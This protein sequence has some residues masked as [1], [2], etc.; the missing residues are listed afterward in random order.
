MTFPEKITDIVNPES[1]EI[2]ENYLQLLHK[3][4]PLVGKDLC[5]DAA[6][7][8]LVLKFELMNW[9]MHNPEVRKR[10]E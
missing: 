6:R 5:I 10:Y 9:K 7:G 3:L 8:A 1:D 4:S 2:I